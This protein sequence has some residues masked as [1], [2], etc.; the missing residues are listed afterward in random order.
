M[1]EHVHVN[2]LVSSTPGVVASLVFH[3]PVLK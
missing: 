1:L 3:Y 2:L